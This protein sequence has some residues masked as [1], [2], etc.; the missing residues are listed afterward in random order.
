AIASTDANGVIKISRG[1]KKIAET[2]LI[3]EV[4]IKVENVG[5]LGTRNA[6]AKRT[7][8]AQQPPRSVLAYLDSKDNNLEILSMPKVLRLGV[9]EGTETKDLAKEKEE[10]EDRAQRPSQMM[11]MEEGEEQSEEE[12]SEKDEPNIKSGTWLVKIDGG[13]AELTV[14]VVSEKGGTVV[15]KVPLKF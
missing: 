6:L 7:R 1:N 15:K 12:D 4:K 5:P 3:A 14:R 13:S 8:Y 2:A 10:R 11:M 9:I